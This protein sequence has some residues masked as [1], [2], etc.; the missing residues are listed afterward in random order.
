MQGLLRCLSETTQ[1]AHVVEETHFPVPDPGTGRIATPWAIH[2]VQTTADF[3][4]GNRVLSWFV[5]GLIFHGS[6]DNGG[7][8][9]FPTLAVSIEP[10][11]GWQIHT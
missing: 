10:T 11:T 2:Q 5:G 6:H 7:D 1:L 9:S 3:A 4:R 8:G